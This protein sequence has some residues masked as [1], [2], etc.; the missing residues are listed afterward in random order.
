M[1][2]PNSSIRSWVTS[3]GE[4]ANLQS[5]P[6]DSAW[7]FTCS[8]SSFGSVPSEIEIISSSEKPGS[9]WNSFSSSCCALHFGHQTAKD[10]NKTGTS[11]PPIVN[12]SPVTERQRAPGLSQ[13][14]SGFRGIC[15]L[16]NLHL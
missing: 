12:V 9:V 4:I 2:G 11:K 5:K 3:I 16:L 14:G 13:R 6:L 8:A 1:P 7:F 15:C 10:S